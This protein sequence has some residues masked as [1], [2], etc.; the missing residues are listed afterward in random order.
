MLDDRVGNPS[1]V[2]GVQVHSRQAQLVDDADEGTGT[3]R[4]PEG[5]DSH[6]N[7]PTLGLGD[8]DRR[9]G[10][11]EQVAQI[12]GVVALGSRIGLVV[13]QQSDGGVEIGQ[14]GAADVNLH[15]GPPTRGYGRAFAASV[16]L[17]D[18]SEDTTD[19]A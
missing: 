17:D 3:H 18:P 9:G 16:L 1:P 6:A 2:G 19:C 12:V 13:R 11:E 15:K 5:E 4:W 8:D 10:N 7:H 14:S